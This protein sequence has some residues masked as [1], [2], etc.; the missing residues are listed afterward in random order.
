[1]TVE[2]RPLK[3]FG[4]MAAATAALLAYVTYSGQKPEVALEKPADPAAIAVTVVPEGQPEIPAPEPAPAAPAAP[5]PAAEVKKPAAAPEFDTV[6][7]EQSGEAIV[8][9]TAVPGSEV[10]LKL[11]GEVVGKGVANND[12]A[13][14]VVPEKPLAAGAGQLSLEQKAPGSQDVVESEQTVA[15]AV[16][17]PKSGDQPMVALL[18]PEA[19]AKV[20]Q[21]P[22]APAEPAGATIEKTTPAEPE[23]QSAAVEPATAPPAEPQAAPAAAEPEVIPGPAKMKVVLD[24]VDYTDRGDIV[25]SG[26]AGAGSNVR[27]YVDNK[28]VGDATSG[29]D[30]KWSWTGKSEIAPGSHALRVDQIDKTGK[31]MNRV[32]IPFMREEPERVVALTEP[33][34]LTPP[35]N[36]EPAATTASGETTVAA[37]TPATDPPKGRVIIQPGNNLWKLSRVI[38]GRGIHYSVIYQ[39][40]RDQIRNPNRIYPG[41][42]FSTPN[43]TPPEQIDPK[44]K[45]PLTTEE[46]GATLN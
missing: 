13:W 31:V 11:N 34:Q 46:G 12:G 45:I 29:V 24:S 39:A 35:A 40:N 1:M 3:I 19:P 32:E 25:F 20:L 9:G 17:E 43:A 4:G 15:V 30:G 23:Q 16:P 37:A 38:Y 14:V 36:P 22:D 18:E 10:T 21:T 41:Q 7:V 33:E 44:R 42:I 5:A 27:V 28:S 2:K 26:R 6:R 8:A